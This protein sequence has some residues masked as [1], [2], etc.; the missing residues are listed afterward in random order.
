MVEEVSVLFG[1]MRE[2]ILLLLMGSALLLRGNL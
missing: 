2:D 1:L